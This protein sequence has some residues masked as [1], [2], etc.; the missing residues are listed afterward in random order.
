MDHFC[1]SSI[2]LNLRMDN[3]LLKGDAKYNMFRHVNI[4]HVLNNLVKVGYVIAYIDIYFES[5]TSKY[6]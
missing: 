5:K 2:I 3:K 1:Y 6:L 4:E